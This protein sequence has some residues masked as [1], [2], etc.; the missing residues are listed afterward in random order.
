[1]LCVKVAH[2]L[3]L[4]SNKVRLQG[5]PLR[6]IMSILRVKCKLCKVASRH[7]LV[8]A[9]AGTITEKLALGLSFS[10]NKVTARS[11]A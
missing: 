3:T 4:N 2:A 7:T 8:V 10:I 1:M 5:F 6:V 9:E 11:N